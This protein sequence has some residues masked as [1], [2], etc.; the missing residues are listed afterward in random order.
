MDPGNLAW[1]DW[2]GRLQDRAGW[3]SCEVRPR[4][5]RQLG[6]EGAHWEQAS[7]QTIRY[8]MR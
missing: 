8:D 6:Q 4:D 5:G 2:A 3:G 7:L 1:E